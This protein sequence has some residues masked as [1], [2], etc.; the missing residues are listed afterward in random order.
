MTDESWVWKDL[1]GSVLGLGEI[2]FPYLR[3]GNEEEHE[4]PSQDRCVP[5]EI[6]TPYLSNTSL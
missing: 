2:L 1:E 4:K 5:A 6:R 3:G